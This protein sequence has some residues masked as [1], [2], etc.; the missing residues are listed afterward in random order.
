[1]RKKVLLIGGNGFIGKNLT[2]SLSGQNIRIRILDKYSEK[3]HFYDSM[4][5]NIEFAQVDIYNTSSLLDNL[6]D[7]ENIIWLVHTSVPS[8]S[9]VDLSDDLTTNIIP[10]INFL[11]KIKDNPNI[12]KFIYLSS[13]GTVYGD[14]PIYE[15]IKEDCTI[16]P[17]S[18][19]GL[20]KYIAE[21][22]IKLILQNSNIS[23]FILRPSNVYGIYQNLNKP[24]GIIGHAFKAALNGHPLFLYNNGEIIRDFIHVSDLSNA[25]FKCLNSQ[26][27][28]LTTTIFNI[29][30][31][32]PIS[33][34][35]I[36]KLINEITGININIINKPKREFDCNYNVL[37]CQKFKLSFEWDTNISLRD[38][39]REVW[40][41]IQVDQSK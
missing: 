15:P 41:W 16:N 35:Q 25:I 33:M 8:N 29:G 36:I 12:E 32:T 1:M 20:T 5:D 3:V 9:M 19:Y 27:P 23:T 14:P 17:I 37:D 22:Y 38:G 26:P 6:G 30:S 7:Y 18:S 21:K 2:F 11:N 39:L 28:V 4:K 31:G 24:Q 10:L 13:G 34:N 40:D